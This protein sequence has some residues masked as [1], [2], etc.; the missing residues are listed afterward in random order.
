MATPAPARVNRY[1]RT[2]V[3]DD[4][5]PS[6][7]V[8]PD[9]LKPI[10]ARTRLISVVLPGRLPR[11][12]RK[13]SN[14]AHKWTHLAQTVR[15]YRYES[16]ASLSVCG[17]ESAKLVRPLSPVL[18]AGRLLPSC[19]MVSCR[20]MACEGRRCSLTTLARQRP[21]Q[22]LKFGRSGSMNAPLCE[23]IECEPTAP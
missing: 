7:D 19:Q 18:Q 15:E 17:F 23:S 11:G 12:E 21:A 14:I 4:V 20:A 6:A 16:M 22:L 1:G 5:R 8:C 2:W 10:K 9:T 3:V 13:A